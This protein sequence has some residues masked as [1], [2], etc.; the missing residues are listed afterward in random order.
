MPVL[1]IIGILMVVL[2]LGID[3]YL[4]SD[5]VPGNTWSEIAHYLGILSPFL[6]WC[7]GFLAGHFWPYNGYRPFNHTNGIF[8]LVWLTWTI[9]VLG[10]GC[11]QAG[12]P[13]PPWLPLIPAYFAGWMLWGIR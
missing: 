3:V 10:L 6:P 4:A 5:H 12:Y 1:H 7:W 11:R 2:F 9:V 13:I 8:V